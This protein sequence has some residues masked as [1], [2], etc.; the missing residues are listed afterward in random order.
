MSG[1]FLFVPFVNGKLRQ[2]LSKFQGS[3]IYVYTRTNVNSGETPVN[4]ASAGKNAD[5]VVIS[6]NL[7][8]EFEVLIPITLSSYLFFKKK[9]NNNKF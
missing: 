7:A 4:S 1:Y 8:P 9:T 3:F 2:K 6:F 5:K